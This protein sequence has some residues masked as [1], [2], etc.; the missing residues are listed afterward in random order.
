LW[1][2]GGLYFWRHREQRWDSREGKLRQVPELPANPLVLILI[3]CFNEAGSG[4]PSPV[5]L[6]LP[7][8]NWTYEY[9][10][11][12]QSTN[13]AILCYLLFIDILKVA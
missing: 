8:K 12:E 13:N 7:Q 10:F 6:L 4:E 5:F 11:C 9:Y 1:I 2:A 3:P